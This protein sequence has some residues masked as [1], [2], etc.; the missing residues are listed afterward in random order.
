LSSAVA[1]LSGW[2]ETDAEPGAG[3]GRGA[4]TAAVGCS[5]LPGCRP[6]GRL[7][8]IDRLIPATRTIEAKA[9]ICLPDT[10]LA[11]RRSGTA[12]GAGSG[13]PSNRRIAAAIAAS[14][15]AGRGGGGSGNRPARSLSSA[16]QRARMTS[17]Q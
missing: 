3:A 9:P 17:R 1:G 13:T 15:A 8:A 16:I 2:L 14:R 4:V 10:H 6:P 5:T 11:G 12:A 7:S